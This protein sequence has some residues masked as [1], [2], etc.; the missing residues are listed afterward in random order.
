VVGASDRQQHGDHFQPAAASDHSG[1]LAVCFYDRRNDTHNF[2]I[3]RYCANSTNGGAS[4][5][6][7]T[8]ISTKSFLSVVNQDVQLNQGGVGNYLG[9]YDT[10]APDSTNSA[11]GSAA[12]S[13]TISAVRQT[14]RS[15]S[16]REAGRNRALCAPLFWTLV[17]DCF[18]QPNAL[19]LIFRH[20]Q[21]NALDLIFR[22]ARLYF[23]SPSVR[24]RALRMV[25]LRRLRRNLILLDCAVNPNPS[26]K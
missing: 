16:S 15:T 1:R 8:R 21:P 2:Y 14:C 24:N 17:A 9:D 25:R 3:D 23:V 26:A 5:S 20:E 6:A 11:S 19:D 13:P 22:A 18:Q 7:N 4:F 12:A 10:L